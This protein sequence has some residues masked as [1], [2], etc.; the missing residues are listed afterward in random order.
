V[1]RKSY[2]L[3]GVMRMDVD[4]AIC[5]SNSQGMIDG[6]ATQD[7]EIVWCLKGWYGLTKFSIAERS[8]CSQVEEAYQS[9]RGSFQGE[10]ISDNMQ[11]LASTDPDLSP[12][13]AGA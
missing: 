5:R 1:M 2:Q 4:T 6:C 10:N 9:S 13:S 3:R 12:F 8:F 11:I 7:Q